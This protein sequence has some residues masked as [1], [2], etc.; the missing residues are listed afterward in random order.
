MT[1]TSCMRK[2]DCILIL[3]CILFG[4]PAFG[5]THVGG[6]ISG[7]VTWDPSG[8]PYITDSS[9]TIAGGATLTISPGVIIRFSGAHALTVNGTLH[10]VGEESNVIT[11]TSDQASPGPGD[12]L[13][14]YFNQ[15]STNSSLEYCLIEYGGY[16]NSSTIYCYQTSP[17]I[18]HNTIHQ[19][20]STAIYVNWPAYPV[21]D[22]NTISNCGGTAIYLADQF[23]S[24]LQVTNN[25]IN[26][27]NGYAIYGMA[28]FHNNS[29]T[30]NAVNGI[31]LPT[32][33][34]GAITGHLY[35][36][37]SLAYIGPFY[38]P[39]SGSELTIDPGSVIKFDQNSWLTN[40]GTLNAQGTESNPIVFT[41][42][43]DDTWAGDTNNDGNGSS[44]AAGDWLGMYLLLPS[45]STNFDHCIIR[46]G[47]YGNNNMIYDDGG[48]LTIMN[49]EIGNCA[50]NG[51]YAVSTTNPIVIDGNLFHHCS[52]TGIYYENFT[53]TGLIRN[54]TFTNCA[55][56]AIQGMAEFH[57]NSGSGNAT[58]GIKLPSPSSGYSI[59]GHLYGDNSMAFIGSVAVASG[60][61]LTIDAGVVMKFDDSNWSSFSGTLNI[62]GTGTNPVVLTSL[63]DDSWAGDTNNDGA[64]TTPSPGDWRGL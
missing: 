5:E 29:G 34:A 39:G 8:N 18:R 41:S 33:G 35:G 61:T 54:N 51:L 15:T 46:Y 57:N 3:I 26:G 2:S 60:H 49:S 11:F 47:G 19:L 24:N 6:T 36:D 37:N 1:A 42:L 27:C 56:Y 20:S 38:V 9:V 16:S 17:I 30:N 32:P 58:N 53:D 22:D 10:A 50:W 63:R 40:G 59:S 52:A 64:G 43:R 7:N 62:Q 4:T 21:I 23:N 55:G 44:P 48:P 25:E 28:E 14:I 12:W 13:Y 31:K 45:V